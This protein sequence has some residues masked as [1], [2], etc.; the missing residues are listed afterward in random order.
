MA[1][2][3]VRRGRNEEGRSARGLFSGDKARE[4][5]RERGRQSLWRQCTGWAASTVGKAAAAG[6]E[7]AARAGREDEDRGVDTWRAQN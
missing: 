7:R 4:K 2:P 1:E 3:S 6:S 5:R